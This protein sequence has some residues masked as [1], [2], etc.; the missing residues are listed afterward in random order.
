VSVDILMSD[1]PAGLIWPLN[2]IIIMWPLKYQLN[3]VLNLVRSIAPAK[4]SHCLAEAE[5]TVV[6]QRVLC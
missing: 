2:M 4:I 3:L 5:T 6:V 1:A